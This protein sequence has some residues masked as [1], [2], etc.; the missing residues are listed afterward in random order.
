MALSSVFVKFWSSE[1]KYTQHMDE[2]SPVIELTIAHL[3]MYVCIY[4]YGIHVK[5]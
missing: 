4:I 3:Y 2:K 1:E 5:C